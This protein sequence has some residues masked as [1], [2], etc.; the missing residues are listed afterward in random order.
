ML[1]G[2]IALLSLLITFREGIAWMNS[3][4]GQALPAQVQR[5]YTISENAQLLGYDLNA[6]VFSPG[7]RLVFNAY[8]YARTQPGVDYSSILRLSAEGASHALTHKLHPADLPTSLFWG[9]VGYV[10]DRYDVHLPADAPAGEYELDHRPV[11]C[12]TGCRWTNARGK[13]KRLGPAKTARRSA[14]AR[15]SRRYA[16]RRPSIRPP[17]RDRHAR[18]HS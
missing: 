11:P 7:D 15:S 17:D 14:A 3:P 6:D 2:A 12:A 5:Q 9:P 10:V 18:R 1:G 4:P 8:W 16:S 13:S